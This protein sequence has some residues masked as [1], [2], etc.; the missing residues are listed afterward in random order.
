MTVAQPLFLPAGTAAATFTHAGGL[1]L[2]EAAL[3]SGV[4]GATLATIP[5]GWV[6]GALAAKKLAALKLI[7]DAQAANQ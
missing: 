4:A 7:L 3:A 2:S 1:V 5:A 6:Y